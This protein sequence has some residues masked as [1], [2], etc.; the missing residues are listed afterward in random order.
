[1]PHERLLLKLEALG[2]SGD[3]LKWIHS[4]LTG[5]FQRVIIN[6]SFS[7]SVLEYLKVQ[8]WE[9]LMYVNDI[10]EVVKHFTVKLFAD[11]VA[12]YKHVQSMADCDLLQ[13]DLNSI[14]LWAACWLLRLNPL[15]C[16]ALESVIL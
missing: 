3:L 12:L 13:Q 1:V 5:C 14:L 16:E 9:F 8:F 6:G 11:D 2:V 15:K 7:Q 4:F 10:Q